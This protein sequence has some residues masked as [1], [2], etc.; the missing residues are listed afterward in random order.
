S[1]ESRYST[2]PS[3]AF[4]IGLGMVAPT[5]LAH[6]SDHAK[7]L[8]LRSLY[9]G[10]IVGCQLFSEPGAGSDLA[11]LQT[12]A[13]R[14]GEEWIVNGQ[15]V[16]NSGTMEADRGILVTRTDSSLPKHKGLSFFLIE[17]EQPGIEVRPIRQLNGE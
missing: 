14:D 12:R 13:E 10:E 15:K 9:R 4:T 6:A 7:D 1:L 8:Y 5:I 2:P 17:V 11:G 3:G 16:W